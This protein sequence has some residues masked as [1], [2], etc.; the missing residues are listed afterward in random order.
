MF[1]SI[2]ALTDRMIKLSRTCTDQ[3]AREI[4]ETKIILFLISIINLGDRGLE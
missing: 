1:G 2:R 4:D 3:L